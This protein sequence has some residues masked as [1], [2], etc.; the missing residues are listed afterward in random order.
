MAIIKGMKTAD[1]G[2]ITPYN[3]DIDKLASGVMAREGRAE[4]TRNAIADA[5]NQ[6]LLKETRDN[7]EDMALAQKLEQ[8][9]ASDVDAMLDK[10]DADYSMISKGDLQRLA[11]DYMGKTEWRALTN[12]KIQTDIYNDEMRKMQAAGKTPFV[13][14]TDPNTVSLYDEKGNINHLTN[15]FD[16]Q[17]LYDH[18][19]AAKALFN[20][21]GTHLK[22]TSG[23]TNLYPKGHPK[24]GQL[25]PESE[26]HT[27]YNRW[28]RKHDSNKENV[29]SIINDGLD[30]FLTD[31]AGKQYYDIFYQEQT[32]NDVSHEDADAYAREKVVA[33]IRTY[34]I[35]EYNTTTSELNTL[36]QVPG[37]TTSSGKTVS[38]GTVTDDEVSYDAKLHREVTISSDGFNSGELSAEEYL[39]H[40]TS[41]DLTAVDIVEA[42]E[43]E[44]KDQTNN[45][46]VMA[47][48]TA[49]PNDHDTRIGVQTDRGTLHT[50]AKQLG[51]A[52]DPTYTV[53]KDDSEID[54]KITS[55]NAQI[56]NALNNMNEYPTQEQRDN[57]I[58]L[59]NT[60]RKLQLSLSSKDD[61]RRSFK[62]DPDGKIFL[63]ERSIQE[64]SDEAGDELFN[65]VDVR[66]ALNNNRKLIQ[67][68]NAMD[69]QIFNDIIK[70]PDL[71]QT[72]LPTYSAIVNAEGNLEL[73]ISPLLLQL[74][75]QYE[76][77]LTKI[78]IEDPNDSDK[79]IIKSTSGIFEEKLLKAKIYRINE[80]ISKG[81]EF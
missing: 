48:V 46:V 12:A 42:S 33:L 44:L 39:K 36:T 67:N 20:T 3:E 6:M 53:I 62:D 40:V 9:F 29:D 5:R 35:S 74:K 21:L 75:D 4:E 25:K 64:I 31:P 68:A 17:E 70:N 66:T 43:D 77:A 2:S 73:N 69:E 81:K 60:K 79:L 10:A 32:N 23:Y 11:G 61:Y 71:E 78:Y 57:L 52:D 72:S 51:I 50:A 1:M 22:T 56:D 18:S 49:V 58:K 59:K 80:K 14:G 37:T 8:G 24:A 41:D 47:M 16:V 19:K 45:N 38:K 13:L 34:G 27:Y 54:S 26:W 65:I 28:V 15:T 30:G 76:T 63:E 55:I 7:S